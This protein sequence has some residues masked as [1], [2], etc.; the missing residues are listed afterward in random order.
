MMP[1]LTI[2]HKHEFCFPNASE[3]R[4]LEAVL[5]FLADIKQKLNHM[6][7]NTDLKTALEG[8]TATLTAEIDQIAAK[9]A[10]GGVSQEN[11]DTV[12]ALKSRIAG[13]I[14]DAPVEEPPAEPAA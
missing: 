7:S 2:V 5:H 4:A 6:P 8:V 11:I 13:I 1:I 9:L 10:E 3:P 14:P 12:L